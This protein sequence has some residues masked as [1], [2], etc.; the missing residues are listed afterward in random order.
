MRQRQRPV[1]SV[2][3]SDSHPTPAN[4]VHRWRHVHVQH[5]PAF[6]QQT[7]RW[8]DLFDNEWF[9][10]SDIYQTNIVLQQTATWVKVKNTLYHDCVGGRHFVIFPT[11]QITTYYLQKIW[12]VSFHSFKITKTITILNTIT[13]R[14][15]TLCACLASHVYELEAAPLNR[16]IPCTLLSSALVTSINLSSTPQMSLFSLPHLNFSIF[17]RAKKLKLLLIIYYNIF[18]TYDVKCIIL[19]CGHVHQLR[20]SA[21]MFSHTKEFLLCIKATVALECILISAEWNFSLC[22]Y[23]VPVVWLTAGVHWEYLLCTHTHWYMHSYFI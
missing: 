7:S 10:A 2:S 9:Q 20:T 5:I 19:N 8:N 16:R 3:I 14:S 1:R 23:S 4:H 21:W 22:C 13:Q 17:T 11:A 15:Q 18:T 6:H 12:N